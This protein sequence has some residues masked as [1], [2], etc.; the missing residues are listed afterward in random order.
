MSVRLVAFLVW[1]AVAASAAY[2]G[3][4]LGSTPSALPATVQP[5]AAG[6]LRGDLGRLFALPADAPTPEA[7]AAPP[8][9]LAARFQL[10]GV[11][12]PRPGDKPSTQGVALVGIDGKPPR[13]YRVGAPVDGE[14]V[15]LAVTQRGASFGPT[16][17]APSFQLELPPLPPPATGRLQAGVAPSADAGVPPGFVVPPATFVPPPPPTGLPADEPVDDGAAATDDHGDPVETPVDAGRRQR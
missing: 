11:M 15:L 13:P 8:P 2:W 16:G 14:L 9:A 4:R 6:T 3:L 17:G 1:A 10:L 12:A 7:A 5:V